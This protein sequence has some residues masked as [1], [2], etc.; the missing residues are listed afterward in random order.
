MSASL[1]N[2]DFTVKFVFIFLD[3]TYTSD[4][5]RQIFNLNAN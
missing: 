4:F 3:Y 1:N 5:A 2:N